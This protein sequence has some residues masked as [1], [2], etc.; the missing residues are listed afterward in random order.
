MGNDVLQEGRLAT[1]QESRFQAAK[2]SDMR[3]ASC[4]KVDFLMLRNRI[5]RLPIVQIKAVVSRK[6][7]NLQL[8]RNRV[9]RL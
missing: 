7:V 9:L 8:L 4:K 6:E 3:I 1:A 5:I 2:R